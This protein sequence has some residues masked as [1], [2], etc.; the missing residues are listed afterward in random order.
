MTWNEF[1]AE[2]P[3][4]DHKRLMLNLGVVLQEVRKTSETATMNG[5]V[6]DARESFVTAMEAMLHVGQILKLSLRP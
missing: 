6:D 3:E 5:N 4:A 1:T 2:L